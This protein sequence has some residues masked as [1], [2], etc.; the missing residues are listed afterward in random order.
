MALF[1]FFGKKR[2][3]N[4]LIL[5]EDNR[6]VP[7]QLEVSKGYMVD[8][9]HSE[10]W[11]VT[12]NPNSQVPRRGT[13]VHYRLI[14]ERDAAPI[15]IGGGGLTKKD[16]AT[17]INRIAQESRKAAQYE[18]QKHQGKDKLRMLLGVSVLSIAVTT[19]LVLVFQLI[20]SG[21]VQF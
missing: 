21:N 3:Q 5:T 18:I 2:L 19:C 16:L 4:V 7:A 14:D 8:H 15:E 9:G 12:A 10:A 20:I 17:Q 11:A 13:K 6:I 1:G